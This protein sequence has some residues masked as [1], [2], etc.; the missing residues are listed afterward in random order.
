[1]ISPWCKQVNTKSSNTLV[2]TV[3]H[4]YYSVYSILKVKVVCIN[5]WIDLILATILRLGSFSLEINISHR[6]DSR[7][8]VKISIVLY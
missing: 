3:I 2:A 6:Q 4:V 5:L 1:M 7:V 8:I